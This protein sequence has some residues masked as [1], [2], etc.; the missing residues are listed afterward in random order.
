MKKEILE[1]IEEPIDLKAKIPWCNL[2]YTLEMSKQKCSLGECWKYYCY[3]SKLF[4]AQYERSM[5]AKEK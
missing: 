4:L 3:D 2:G 1:K 5:E